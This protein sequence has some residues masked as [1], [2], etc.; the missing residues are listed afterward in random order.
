MKIGHVQFNIGL[1]RLSGVGGKTPPQRLGSTLP[2]STD[3]L[4]GLS[5]GGAAFVTIVTVV[6]VIAF[7]KIRSHK[8]HRPLSEYSSSDGRYTV[9][10][11]GVISVL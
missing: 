5:V 2:I 8:E 1:V 6:L 10:L 9:Y 3:L 7:I 11:S 4:I